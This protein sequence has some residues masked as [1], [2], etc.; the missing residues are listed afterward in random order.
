[1]TKILCTHPISLVQTW[2]TLRLAAI[3]GVICC[4]VQLADHFWA[5]KLGWRNSVGTL[6]PTS[7]HRPVEDTSEE[8]PGPPTRPSCCAR[9]QVGNSN[10][11]VIGLSWT[12]L[13][14]LSNFSIL[15]VSAPLVIVGRSSKRVWSFS[16][17]YSI[18]VQDWELKKCVRR[19]CP[20]R[21]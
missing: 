18:R 12:Y 1:M 2:S 5:T 4:Q 20:K 19:S 3:V 8:S 9:Q 21:A 6:G 15:I 16:R 13:S 14:Q 11:P 17:G 10:H 7:G